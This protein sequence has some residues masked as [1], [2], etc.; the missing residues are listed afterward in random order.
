MNYL[1]V[2]AVLV[3]VL[4]HPVAASL[5]DRPRA[6]E[7]TGPEVSPSGQSGALRLAQGVDKILVQ[8]GLDKGGIDQSGD[9]SGIQQQFEDTQVQQQFDSS[10]K[11]QRH[12]ETGLDKSGIEEA[13]LDQAGQAAPASPILL[14]QDSAGAT[15]AVSAPPVAAR[16]IENNEEGRA[17][18]LPPGDIKNPYYTSETN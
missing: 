13:I 10:G 8:G 12:D 17:T 14:P 4:A 16:A 1:T 9:K 6:W 7:R 3:V 2:A 5:E 18:G 11:D 15:P